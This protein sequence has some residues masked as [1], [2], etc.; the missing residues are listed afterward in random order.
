MITLNVKEKGYMIH[1]PGV[2]PFRTPAKI[3]VSHVKIQMVISSLYSAG[4]TDYEIVAK[5][6]KKEVIY[7]QDDFELPK[8]G[9]GP[10]PGLDKIDE[11]FNKIEGILKQLIKKSQSEKPPS[12]EQITNKLNALEKLSKQILEKEIVKEIVY[13]S[14]KDGSKTPVIEELDDELFIP[15]IDIDD[16]E[17]KGSVSEKIGELDDVEE[18]ADILSRLKK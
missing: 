13:T 4:V 6:D 1:I 5:E 17:L 8:K 14:S 11:R 3:D 9:S 2:A 12:Q 10:D 18:A 16:M 7:T 15:S